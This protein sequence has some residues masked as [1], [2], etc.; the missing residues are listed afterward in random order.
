VGAF[1]GDGA[2]AADGADEFGELSWGEVQ[3]VGGLG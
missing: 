1:D 2:H 3:D